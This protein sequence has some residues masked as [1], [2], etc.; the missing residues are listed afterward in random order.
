[1]SDRLAEVRAE[2]DGYATNYDDE[3]DHGLRDP[4]V[5]SA[6][7]SLL[8]EHLPA[9]PARVADLGCGSG[10]L[11]VL[12]AEEG[13][14]VSCLDL[15]ERMLDLARAKASDAGVDVAFAQGD[16]SYPSL[17]PGAFDVVLCRHVLWA[18]PDPSDALARWVALLRPGGSLVLV[19]GR[20]STGAGLPARRTTELVREHRSEVAVQHLPEPVYWGREIDDD[21]YLVVSPH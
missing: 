15:S 13:Y 16:A 21:R 19:E 11:S 18:L 12:L 2:W 8:L 20:W 4:S 3:P 10:S 17:E 1:M 9:P 5:R 6:W 7:R 14:D